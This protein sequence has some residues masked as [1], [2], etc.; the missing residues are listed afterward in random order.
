MDIK[1]ETMKM[2][3]RRGAQSEDDTFETQFWALNTRANSII[4]IMMG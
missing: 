1:S 3:M 4:Q 2:K